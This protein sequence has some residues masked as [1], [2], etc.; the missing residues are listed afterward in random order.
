MAFKWFANQNV[1]IAVIEVGLGGRLDSTNVI[2]PDLSIVTSI[3][4]DHCDLLGDTLDK[5]AFE[6]A[7]IFKR[8]VSAVI[9]ETRPET[10]P[11]FS[12]HFAEVNEG[13][14]SASLVF[15][16]ECEPSKWYLSPDILKNMDLRGSYQKKNLRT[17]LAALDVLRSLWKQDFSDN[18]GA[19]TLAGVG[20]GDA[21]ELAVV[22]EGDSSS[23]YALCS[24]RENAL[25]SAGAGNTKAL[26]G[27]GAVNGKIKSEDISISK[28]DSGSI[29]N[30][31]S[32]CVFAK[33]SDLLLDNERLAA[34][35]T[36]TASRMDFHGRWERLSTNPEVLCDIGHNAP[37]LAYNFEQLKGYIDSDEFTSLIIVYGV[38]ADKNFDA[39]M[40]LFPE[41]ATWIF[42][43]PQTRRAEPASRILERYSAYCKMTG[44]SVSRLYVQDSVRDAVALALRTA[45]SYG[46][47]PLV[48]IGGSTFVVS[49]ATKCF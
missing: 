41:N 12:K 1:D 17:V 7:G 37:A 14:S 3:G 48:Y 25:T 46:G 24:V 38:M 26:D 32:I 42:T 47:R 39:I 19:K 13:S 49:E 45:S 33:A 40:P 9:G 35:L 8:G 20:S 23:L 6:K 31:D 15:A 16:E 34:S 28:T 43:T 36:H 30:T 18:S 21:K 22:S 11:V 10:A 44:R 2:V 5:I 4:L 29:F 27:P